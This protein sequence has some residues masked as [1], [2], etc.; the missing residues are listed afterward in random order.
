NKVPGIRA[1]LAYDTF[2]AKMASEH[3]DANILCLGG[4][5]IG[6]AL[7][8]DMV[9]VWIETKFA[10]GRHALRVDKIMGIEKKYLKDV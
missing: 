7:A 6:V 8:K 5:T 2:T 9:K 4:Q 10:G 3:D 1:A